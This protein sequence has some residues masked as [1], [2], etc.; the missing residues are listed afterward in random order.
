MN[1]IVFRYLH[2]KGINGR[3]MWNTWDKMHELLNS[4]KDRYQHFSN[5]RINYQNYPD[6]IELALSGDCGKIV[7]DFLSV[8]PF[9][10]S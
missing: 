8:N 6:G 4:N 1:D 7:M 10:T 3:K 9:I 2:V 5:S